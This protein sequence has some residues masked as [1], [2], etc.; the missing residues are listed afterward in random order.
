MSESDEDDEKVLLCR[1]WNR[2]SQRFR[3]RVGK[4][5]GD[6]MWWGALGSYATVEVE[7]SSEQATGTSE[8][9]DLGLPRGS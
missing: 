4:A 1:L 8:G 9:S 2:L 6:E 3:A 7:S 5:L